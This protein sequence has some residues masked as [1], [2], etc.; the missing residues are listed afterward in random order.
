MEVQDRASRS[1]HVNRK[2]V[3]F[4]ISVCLCVFMCACSCVSRPQYA[5]G[6]QRTTLVVHLTFPLTH[7]RSKGILD[8]HNCV[9]LYNDSG[10]L[11]SG[12]H[13]YAAST[14]YP[15]NHFSGPKVSFNGK[16]QHAMYPFLTH[17]LQQLP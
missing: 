11:N 7:R 15:P 14:L 6:G 1:D 12:P 8:V 16:L 9:R 13:I 4:L 10:N 5:Y 3:F 2:K 17:T